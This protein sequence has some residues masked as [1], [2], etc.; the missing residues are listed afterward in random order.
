MRKQ[1]YPVRWPAQF[2]HE[3]VAAFDSQSGFRV[4]L[5]I[6]PQVCA[7]WERKLLELL[8][9]IHLHSSICEAI[10]MCL[11]CSFHLI[12]FSIHLLTPTSL[13]MWHIALLL[14]RRWHSTERMRDCTTVRGRTLSRQH[15]T[16]SL[17]A[18]QN[19]RTHCTLCALLPGSQCRHPQDSGSQVMRPFSRDTLKSFKSGAGWGM[20]SLHRYTARSF[21]S[22][23]IFN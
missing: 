14:L 15:C 6:S 19:S 17:W 9:L 12:Q 20:C 10:T 11:P 4:R 23:F 5:V 2:T 7:S 13:F 16:E 8:L 1:K 3:L 18:A 21:I 22:I